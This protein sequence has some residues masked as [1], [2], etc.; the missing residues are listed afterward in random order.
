MLSLKTNSYYITVNNNYITLAT[1]RSLS[2]FHINLSK[3]LKTAL[4]LRSKVTEISMY[5]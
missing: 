3:N 4:C 2:T 5:P 1:P